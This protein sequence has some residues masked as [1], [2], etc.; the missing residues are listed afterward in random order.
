MKK[1]SGWRAE[2][3]MPF[4]DLINPDISYDFL[5]VNFYQ[6]F[7]KDRP[8]FLY[9]RSP[10]IRRTLLT[11]GYMGAH[12]RVADSNNATISGVELK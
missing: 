7:E 4:L 11:N 12:S 6:Y 8:L 3:E 1:F 10:S 2:G 9:S 5:G